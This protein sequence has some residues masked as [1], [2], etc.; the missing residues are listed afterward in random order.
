[1]ASSVAFSASTRWPPKSCAHVPYVPSRG[2][3]LRALRGF[4]DAAPPELPSLAWLAAHSLPES[5]E[6]SSYSARRA[7]TPGMQTQESTKQQPR[8]L[9]SFLIFMY[10]SS[11]SGFRLGPP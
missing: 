6:Y 5:L 3:T 7:L 1:M 10:H 11:L 4:G 9:R 8:D 2:A